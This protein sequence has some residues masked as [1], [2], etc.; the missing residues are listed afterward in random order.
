MSL[1]LHSSPLSRDHWNGTAVRI[2]DLFFLG[3]KKEFGTRK[4][5]E[6]RYFPQ[7]YTEISRDD[8]VAKYVSS[9]YNHI[10]RYCKP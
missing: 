7:L 5:G 9:N 3:A 1:T 8:D 4:T 10:L 6:G 2:N